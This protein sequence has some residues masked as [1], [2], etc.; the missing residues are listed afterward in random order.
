[1]SPRF[2]STM[3]SSPTVRAYAHTSSK[4]RMPSAPSASKKAACGLTAT[5]Y[6]QT[7][8]TRPRQKRAYADGGLSPGVRVAAKLDRQQLEPR[9][10]PDDELAS[11]LDDGGREP[12]GEGRGD[13][14]GGSGLH[15]APQATRLGPGGDLPCVPAARSRN[16]AR[17]AKTSRGRTTAAPTTF[18]DELA[19]PIRT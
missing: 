7:A 6:G 19:R 4:A 11:P 2:P 8:S 10:E 12:V 15:A 9:V 17:P 18:P 13:D 14:G 1:M 16:G 3:T 5:T